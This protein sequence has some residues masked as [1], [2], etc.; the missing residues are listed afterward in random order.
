MKTYNGLF[1]KIVDEDNIQKAILKASLGKRKKASVRRTLC[2]ISEIAHKLSQE[3]KTDTWRPVE[4]H[5]TTQINDGVEL[6]KRYIVCPNFASEQCVHHAIM[7]ICEPLFRKKFYQYSCGSVKGHGG[8]Q[9]KK[10]IEKILKKYPAKTKYVAKLDIKK[11]FANAKP[12]FIFHEVRRTIRDRRVL[13]LFALIL[14]AN[15][16]IVDGKVIKGGIPI[17]FY[18]SPIF[19]NIL[20]NPLDH[21]IKEVLGIEYYVRY[22]DDIIMFSPNRRK[23]KRACLSIREWLEARKLRLKPIWQ[24]HRMTS[25]NFIGYQFKKSGLIRIR[26][27]IFLKSVRCVRRV[28]RKKAERRMTIHDCLRILSYMGRFKN[29]QTYSAFRRYISPLINIREMRKRV[30]RHFKKLAKTQKERM[31]NKY[32]MATCRG[33]PAT[34]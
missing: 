6:K 24:V 4:V 19:A 25:V 14:R 29:A 21:Y 17:G 33:Q 2:N 34:A 16:Q 23:L 1:D 5:Q 26:D 3:L 9:A 12:S 8:D 10:Y 7:N 22:M 30:S 13:R 32:D 28:A 31:G 18:T 27:R 20:L 15:K 11:F